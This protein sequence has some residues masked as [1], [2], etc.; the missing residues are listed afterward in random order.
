MT[1]GVFPGR[2]VLQ[3]T[4]VDPVSFKVWKDEAFALW[5]EQ[6]G[7]LYPEGSPSRDLLTRISESYYLVNL[8]DNNFP[9]ESSLW[10]VLTAMFEETELDKQSDVSEIHSDDAGLLKAPCPTTPR[11]FHHYTME[12][13]VETARLVN[14]RPEQEVLADVYAN[15]IQWFTSFQFFFYRNG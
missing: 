1:W 14:E 8:V 5:R 7:K 15:S 4:V 12:D 10:D 11:Y 9:K 6:W 3:P 2:E 13:I